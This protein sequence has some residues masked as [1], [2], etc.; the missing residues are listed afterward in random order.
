MRFDHITDNAG[1]P[2]PS[3]IERLRSFGDKEGRRKL[4]AMQTGR[5]VSVPG[6]KLPYFRVVKESALAQTKIDLLHLRRTTIN[7]ERLNRGALTS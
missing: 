7:V 1:G 6:K 2:S 5:E 3:G 4:A